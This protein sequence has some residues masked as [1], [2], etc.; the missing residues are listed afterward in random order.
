MGDGKG[1]R[2][3]AISR[4][5]PGLPELLDVIPANCSVSSVAWSRDGKSIAFTVSDVGEP[6]E[7]ITSLKTDSSSK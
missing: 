7:W 4:K 2:L 5:Q 6:V 1:H 3:H